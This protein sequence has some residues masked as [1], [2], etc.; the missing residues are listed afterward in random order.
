MPPRLGL[1]AGGGN[2]FASKN[3]LGIK[4]GKD[5]ETSQ[6]EGDENSWGML[7]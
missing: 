2:F 1:K 5:V 6:L 4:V 7:S 3:G